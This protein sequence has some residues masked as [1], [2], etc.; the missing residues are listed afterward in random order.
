M[1]LRF[2]DGASLAGIQPQAV[3]G[4]MVASQVYAEHEIDCWV[5]S[6]T[7]GAQNRL[8]TSLHPKGLAFDLRLPSKT[9]PG[10]DSPPHLDDDVRA[11]LALRLGTAWDVIKHDV[12]SG[13]HIHVE[14]D[15]SHT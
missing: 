13:E 7:D 14:W 15:P 11:L 8:G 1:A 12:G 4:L 2:K 6:V 5:T 3:V 9:W 10:P